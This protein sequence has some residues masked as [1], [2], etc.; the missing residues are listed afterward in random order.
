ME[1]TLVRRGRYDAIRL[2]RRTGHSD[3]RIGQQPEF[4]QP[5]VG[6]ERGPCDS[7]DRGRFL[8]RAD[9]H[10]TE[11]PNDGAFTLHRS[12]GR[13]DTTDNPEI[14]AFAKSRTPYEGRRY[15]HGLD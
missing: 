13:P 15:S 7:G 9:R 8:G 6:D 14:T 3:Q 12:E 4:S 10:H 1:P 2:D 11:S 5:S